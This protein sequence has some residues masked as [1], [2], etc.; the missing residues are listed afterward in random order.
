[1]V[2]DLD[3]VRQEENACL[4]VAMSSVQ[5]GVLS[6]H[7][8]NE[9]TCQYFHTLPPMQIICYIAVLYDVPNVKVEPEWVHPAPRHTRTLPLK[10]RNNAEWLND[11]NPNESTR[12]YYH[13]FS[14]T[15]ALSVSGDG[16]SP[17]STQGAIQTPVTAGGIGWGPLFVD[18][19]VRVVNHSP[20]FRRTYSND[21]LGSAYERADAR[22]YHELT[23]RLPSLE[24]TVKA[25]SEVVKTL[26]QDL[27]KSL[28]ATKN[29]LAQ[30]LIDTQKELVQLKKALDNSNQ[31]IPI[32]VL[33]SGSFAGLEVGG[34]GEIAYL[35]EAEPKR[36]CNGDGERWV[37]KAH[38]R[39]FK[40][41]AESHLPSCA[42]LENPRQSEY[43]STASPTTRP[44]SSE[45]IGSANG[46]M[47]SQT[48]S[49]L[50][51]SRRWN[52]QS[53]SVGWVQEDGNNGRHGGGEETMEQPFVTLITV[54]SVRICILESAFHE[55][56]WV[57]VRFWW[58][59]YARTRS[60]ICKRASFE[61]FPRANFNLGGVDCGEEGLCPGG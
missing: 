57:F 39:L 55:R 44:D 30:G 53:D 28:N 54:Y 26:Q 59:P 11:D 21:S 15:L 18:P 25:T 8:M 61:W 20:P 46:Q 38:V 40:L 4:H 2:D 1:M 60:R 6:Q 41:Q 22:E 34:A 17:T 51:Y 52:W 16:Q 50:I 24:D 35:R 47:A 32:L 14:I 12:P 27:T 49:G 23:Y 9:V 31:G 42:Q 5:F 37:R 7:K 56:L 48:T 36:G 13:S 43:R 58:L 10:Q 19:G 3:N 33:G 45:D 29:E